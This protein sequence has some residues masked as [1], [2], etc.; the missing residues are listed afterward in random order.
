MTAWAAGGR[1]RPAR[2]AWRACLVA[3]G[4]LLPGCGPAEPPEVAQARLEKAVYEQQIAGLEKLLAEAERGDI[5]PADRLAVGIDESV[6]RELVN[7][8][9]PREVRVGTEFSVLMQSAQAYF[10]FTKAGVI[11]EGRLRSTRFPGQFVAVQLLGALDDVRLENGRLAGRVRLVTAQIQGA[12]LGSLARDVLDR[13]VKEHLGE[14]EAAIPA[15]EVPVRL[16]QAIRIKGLDEGPVSVPPGRL[17]VEMSVA[18]LLPAN[19]RLW[20]MVDVKL[21]PWQRER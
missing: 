16:E 2:R 9:L 14:I 11:V 4:L 17:A 3:A 20:V 1:R 12:S 15:F 5:L 21:G 18:R 6:V 13:A 19:E 7:A 10:R 8:T